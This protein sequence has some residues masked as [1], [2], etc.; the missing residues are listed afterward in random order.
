[1][2]NTEVSSD[3]LSALE[4]RLRD[5]LPGAAAH[6]RFPHELSLGRHAGPAPPHARVAAV[7]ILLYPDADQWYIPL[8]LRPATMNSHGGQIGFPGGRL[9]SG[10]TP[11][12]CASRET[13]EELG[14][15]TQRLRFLGR[16]T[17]LYIYASNFRVTP[18]LAAMDGKPEFHAN[19]AEVA[20]VLCLPLRFLWSE[21]AL[22]YHVV[23]RQ[24]VDFRV[25]HL[26]LA[27]QQ[28]W[29][30]TRMMLGELQW[31]VDD[32]RVDSLY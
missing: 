6:R 14:L 30:A 7:L 4:R 25:P 11:E 9:E 19:R 15:D 16:L 3:L 31:L 26:E 1:M 27:G 18:C 12:A 2:S 23:H 5:P 8:I 13:R 21:S 17:E 29:G 22:G 32:C 24:G 28:I 20:D 10:E